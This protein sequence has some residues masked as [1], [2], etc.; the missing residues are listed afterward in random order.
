MQR[1]FLT[2]LA[3]VLLL[4]QASISMASGGYSGGSSAG[5]FGNSSSSRPAR[6]VDQ[7]YEVGKAIFKGRQAGEP[8]L[9][10]CVVADG[11]KVP[12]KRSTV[13]GYKNTTYDNLANSLY[14]CDQP[15]KLVAQGL[16]RDSLLYVLYYLNKRHKL[17]L[18]SS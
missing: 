1:S 14:Q 4:T 18:K 3:S 5:G 7:T 15:E 9:Q 2:F 17:K 8:S 16:T 6:Q 12:L 13:K 10:Y 11:E